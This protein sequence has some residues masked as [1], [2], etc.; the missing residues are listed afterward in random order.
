MFEPVT[1]SAHHE[2]CLVLNFSIFCR[3][4]RKNKSSWKH[5]GVLGYVLTHNDFEGAAVEQALDLLLLC[6]IHFSVTTFRVSW[7]D[8]F[9]HMRRNIFVTVVGKSIVQ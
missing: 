6:L 4:D 3:L 2:S 5:I 1:V 8:D 7:F 9:G